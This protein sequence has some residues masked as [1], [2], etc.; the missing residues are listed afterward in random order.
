M[1]KNGTGAEEAGVLEQRNPQVPG[2]PM[3]GRRQWWHSNCKRTGF[4]RNEDIRPHKN[5]FTD[6]HRSIIHNS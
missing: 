6:V 2:L 5:L 3:R 1:R 4:A